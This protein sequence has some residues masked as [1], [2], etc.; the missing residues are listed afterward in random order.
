MLRHHA[1]GGDYAIHFS[2]LSNRA[3]TRAQVRAYEKRNLVST[4]PGWIPPLHRLLVWCYQS[5]CKE[6][7]RRLCR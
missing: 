7:E 3:T 4:W 6:G 2:W 5:E 1:H